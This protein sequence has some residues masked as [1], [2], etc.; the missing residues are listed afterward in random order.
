[1][2]TEVELLRSGADIFAM[3]LQ[4]LLELQVSDITRKMTPEEVAHIFRACDAFWEHSGDSKDPHAETTS[5]KCTNGFVNTLNVLRHSNL[6]EIMGNQLVRLTRY[7]YGP[8]DWTIGSD[9][10]S[11][12]ISFAVAAE[13]RTQHDFTEKGEG[14]TQSWKRFDIAPTSKVLQVEELVMTLLTLRNVRVGIR[15]ATLHPVQFA[16]EILT[17]VHRSDHY[18]L[19]GARIRYLVHYDIQTWDGP[20]TCPLCR[21]GSRRLRPKHHWRELTCR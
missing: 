14:K 15:A 19:E 11:A 1:M 16:S 10:A 12:T 18:E 9:H 8:N 13:L 6:C 3:G 2:T 21:A 20:E 7:D 17:L 5:G 4:E